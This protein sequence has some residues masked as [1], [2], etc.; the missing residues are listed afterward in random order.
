MVSSVRRTIIDL[1]LTVLA[2]TSMSCLISL[3]AIFIGGGR[4][5]T[6]L[7]S[8]IYLQAGLIPVAIGISI[9]GVFGFVHHQGLA[10]GMRALWRA[11]PQWQVFIFLLL[12]SLVISGEVAF[13][14]VMRAT[15]QVVLWQQHI[16]LVCMLVCS[17]AYLV[18]YARANSY[19]GSPAAM[20]G[21]WM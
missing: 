19:P 9:V 5:G 6:D 16:P 12:N 17:S 10:A 8:L 15:E 13:V 18:L 3:M 11:I 14:I 2:I 4:G 20:S 7:R 21:R 1:T